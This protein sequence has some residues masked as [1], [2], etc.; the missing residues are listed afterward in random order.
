LLRNILGKKYEV[1]NA[2]VC[3]S[4]FLFNYKN[5]EDSLWKY[6]PDIIIQTISNNDIWT[7]IP[8]YGGWDRF[9]GKTALKIKEKPWWFYF[10]LLSNTFRL[11]IQLLGLSD[12]T[13]MLQ[14][15]EN[16]DDMNRIQ[17]IWLEKIENFAKEWG[18][19]VLIVG[20][21]MKNEVEEGE[22]D[23]PIFLLQTVSEHNVKSF[24][25]LKCYIEKMQS[26]NSKSNN[27]YWKLDGHH[28]SKG[29]QLM[30]ECVAEAL[31]ESGF[32]EN[33]AKH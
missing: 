17:K 28:N 33:N 10:A 6:K 23:T 5:L 31:Q 27:F 4:D 32:L 19:Q 3:G 21:P 9:E 20:L 26:N 29:Y 18:C 30:A 22:Y 12:Y 8:R 1:F 15:S 24:D 7:D 13:P 2:G 11:S 25:L 16:L 14:T